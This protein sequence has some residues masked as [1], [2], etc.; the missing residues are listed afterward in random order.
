MITFGHR[1]FTEA[2]RDT[3][4]LEVR[5]RPNR[6]DVLIKMGRDTRDVTRPHEHTSQGERPEEKPSLLPL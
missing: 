3:E 5:L 6:T 4:D 2:V 1:P